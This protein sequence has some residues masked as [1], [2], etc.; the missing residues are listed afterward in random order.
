MGGA[1]YTRQQMALH[2]SGTVRVSSQVGVVLLLALVGCT[3]RS[4]GPYD[5]P[6]VTDLRA[7][8][9]DLARVVDARAPSWDGPK[10]HLGAD[11]VVDDECLSG[12]CVTSAESRG[13]F[14]SVC[15]ARC[16]AARPCL[17]GVCLSFDGNEYWC[18]PTCERLAGNHDCFGGFL[19]CETGSVSACVPP[20]AVTC[21]PL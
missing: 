14:D 1:A 16:D 5:E 3:D 11:C 6:G 19:C 10:R 17:E 2:C 20:D 15:G 12:D 13:E 4:L 21:Q 8:V 7:E 18:V 9:A